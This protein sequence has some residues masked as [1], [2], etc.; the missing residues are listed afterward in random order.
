[1][2]TAKQ[3]AHIEVRWERVS[4][5]SNPEAKAKALRAWLFKHFAVAGLQWLDQTTAYK[6]IEGLKE[7]ERRRNCPP[8]ENEG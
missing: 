3:L 6:A 8:H 2:A 4:I 1:M 7:M 5:K